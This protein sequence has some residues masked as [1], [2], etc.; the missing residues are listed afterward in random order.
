MPP[1]VPW[2]EV[3]VNL[4]EE[5]AGTVLESLKSYQVH[6]S[7]P[8]TCTLC[9]FDE[10]HQ[11]RYRLLKCVSQSCVAVAHPCPWRGKLLVCL[12]TGR[13]FIYEHGEHFTLVSSPKRLKLS[14][15]QKTFCRELTEERL[16]PMRIRHALSRKFGL[17]LE[18][19]P[20]LGT[21]Q[22]YVNHYARTKLSNHD[23]VADIRNWVGERAFNGAESMTK[24]F[25]FTW[26]MDVSGR[27]V[28]G[29]GSDEKP[30]LVGLSSKAMILRLAVPPES[31]I[32]HIDATYKLNRLD[33]PVVVVGISDR[34][35]G[36]HV[37]ALFIVS[38][39]VEEIYE[40]AL[41]AL[42]RIF[43]WHTG[44]Q[45]SVQFAMGDAD[46]AQYNAL[47]TVFGNH[48]RYTFLMCF[49]HVMKNVHKAL[50][51]FPSNIYANLV[52]AIYDMHFASNEYEF[53]VL[54]DQVLQS[55]LAQPALHKFGAYMRDQWLFGQFSNWQ[56]FWT[57]SGYATTNNPVETFNNVLKRDYTLR[58]RLTMGMLLQELS[59][60]CHHSAG[61]I[62]PFLY[63]IIPST[64]LIRRAKEMA[65]ANLLQIWQGNELVLAP[66]GQ[67][68]VCVLS[69]AAR[70][71]QVNP[72]KRSEIGIAVS[73]QMGSNY[74][75]M[76]VL[77]QPLAGWPVNLQAQWCPCKF[78]L[79]F[80]TC[81][82][83]L[84]ALR[85]TS[86]VDT[87]GRELLVSRKKKKANGEFPP[88]S[89]IGRAPLVGPALTY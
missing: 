71:V 16:K 30:F 11:M 55:W 34:S 64:S 85:M 22:N 45:L 41:R 26:A 87:H 33:Y 32:L 20:S 75:R 5:N 81:V 82:H 57:P 65:R 42:S 35:R 25:T 27:P 53:S 63:T 12:K 76:E 3:A 68:I 54:R 86:R 79:V 1:R 18:A 89:L 10:L 39:E 6:K 23:R 49:F 72:T 13:S 60:C 61:S 70:R 9:A 19:L 73:A 59:N 69:W 56:A 77:N 67:M 24:P 17:E 2:R 46:K 74:A 51:G 40:A 52:G 4:T 48:P 36:F 21:V 28:V 88:D 80:G 8:V 7:D 62:R 14:S 29:D 83:V 38:Q 43:T 78:C 47:R 66:G 15:A 84:F 58:R 31:F 50:K 44:R 37:V